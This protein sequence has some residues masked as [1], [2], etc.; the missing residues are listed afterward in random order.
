LLDQ[1]KCILRSDVPD[2]LVAV[3]VELSFQS[4]VF[5]MEVFG[6]CSRKYIRITMP[7][8]IEMTGMPAE[9]IVAGLVEASA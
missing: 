7:K 5:R 2:K 1:A 4:L 9:Y 3:E 8:K 6:S